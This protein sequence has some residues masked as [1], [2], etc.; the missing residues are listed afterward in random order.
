MKVHICCTFL[1]SLCCVSDSISPAGPSEVDWILNDS[2]LS[3]CEVNLLSLVSTRNIGSD[4]T[5][6]NTGGGITDFLISACNKFDRKIKLNVPHFYVEFITKLSKLD[7]ALYTIK[8]SSGS[9][10]VDS[11]RSKEYIKIL[12]FQL[13]PSGKANLEIIKI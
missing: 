3:D 1:R 10:V 6:E 13:E 7:D 8:I 12:M 2:G 5:E 9:P 4:G 11:F